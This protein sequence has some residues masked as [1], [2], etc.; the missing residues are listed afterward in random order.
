LSV[1]F[2]LINIVYKEQTLAQFTAQLNNERLKLIKVRLTPTI[3]TNNGLKAKL[4]SWRR[5]FGP[6]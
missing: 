4:N 6:K 2:Y 5:I 3:N 1:N